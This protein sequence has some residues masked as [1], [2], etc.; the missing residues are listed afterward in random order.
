MSKRGDD[1]ALYGYS[2]NSIQPDDGLI[3]S[4]RNM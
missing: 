2:D 3:R 1:I 4:G